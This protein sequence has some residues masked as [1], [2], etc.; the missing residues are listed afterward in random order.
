MR[1]GPNAQHC[2]NAQHRQTGQAGVWRR[3][4][5]PCMYACRAKLAHANWQCIHSYPSP[6][7]PLLQRLPPPTSAMRRPTL[8]LL[9]RNLPHASLHRIH[10]ASTHLRANRAVRRRLPKALSSSAAAGHSPPAQHAH[11]RKKK[12]SGRRR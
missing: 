8:A 1:S 11:I 4:R 2:P 5:A 6:P 3:H 7:Q 9:R 10:T 12:F